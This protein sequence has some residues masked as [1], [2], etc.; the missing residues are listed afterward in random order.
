S[1]QYCREMTSCEEARF[2]LI[3]CGLTRLD[4]DSDGVPCEA[5]CR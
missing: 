2:Y 1:K 3:S 5:I 4:G